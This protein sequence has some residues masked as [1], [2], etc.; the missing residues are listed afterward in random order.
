MV[1]LVR[2]AALLFALVLAEGL[3][4]GH[5]HGA[6]TVLRLRGA[7]KNKAAGG[8]TE[9]KRSG[10]E[11]ILCRLKKGGSK[12]EVA[13]RAN[14]VEAFKEGKIKKSELLLFEEPFQDFKKGDRP[15]GASIEAAF[16]TTDVSAVVDEILEKGEFQITEKERK[17]M[18]DSKTSEIIDYISHHFH[19]PKTR[20]AVPATRIQNGLES[21]KGLKI[22]PFRSAESQVPLLQNGILRYDSS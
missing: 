10:E 20:L 5:P 21:I 8:N 4:V 13:C 15:S 19:E 17:V 16:G 11:P 9:G 18:L 6:A 3:A 14:K 1:F 2:L 12:W 22:D 7:G